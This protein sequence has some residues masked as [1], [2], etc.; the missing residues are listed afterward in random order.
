[1][2][3]VPISSEEENEKQPKSKKNRTLAAA[4]RW[5]L[6]WLLLTW[7][8][9]WRW[10]KSWLLWNEKT[11][12]NWNF[13]PRK[14]R[15]PAENYADTSRIYKMDSSV[16]TMKAWSILKDKNANKI[17]YRGKELAIDSATLE[18][19]HVEPLQFLQTDASRQHI[20]DFLANYIYQD[21]EIYKTMLQKISSDIIGIT[22]KDSYTERVYKIHQFVGKDIAYPKNEDAIKLSEHWEMVSDYQVPSLITALH[23]I[24]DCNNKTWLFLALCRVNGVLWAIG[25]SPW[26]I[27]P[28]VAY[29]NP[30]I[31]DV[32][33][34]VWRYC[35]VP[36]EVTNPRW[37]KGAISKIH[38]P[39]Y[40]MQTINP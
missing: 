22:D 4:T 31:W 12:S 3:N 24:G 18:S 32:I 27:F 11:K 20:V 1:M 37:T 34:K 2:T 13:D 7:W 36:I 6:L 25:I 30:D 16:S 38:S 15:L 40:A 39:L 5:T 21:A 35:Y 26:H 14:I 23:R 28:M 29:D 8:V 10:E 9:L 33:I 19:L 17:S